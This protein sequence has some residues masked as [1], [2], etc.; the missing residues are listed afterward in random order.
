LARRMGLA[1][2]ASIADI[3]W[4]KTAR[5]LVEALGYS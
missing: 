3:R 2:E 5:R 1:G 4:D